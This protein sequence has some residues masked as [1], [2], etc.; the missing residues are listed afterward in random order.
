MLLVAVPWVAADEPSKLRLPPAAQIVADASEVVDARQ[1]VV[2]ARSAAGA[3]MG[4]P[5]QGC[6][7]ALDIGV[8]DAAIGEVADADGGPPGAVVL[9]KDFTGGQ[10]A[11]TAHARAVAGLITAPGRLLGA[12]LFNAAVVGR[13]PNQAAAASA[14]AMVSALDW[15]TASKVRLVNVS[16]AGPC[17]KLLDLAVQSATA[18]GMVI[19]AA[20]GNNGPDSSPRYPA[21]FDDV[22]AVTAVDA[23]GQ[24]YAQAVQGLHVDYAAPGV[25]V[26]VEDRG[27]L[28][29]ASGTSVATPLVTARLA[30]DGRM[31]QAH[32]LAAVRAL[33]DR[34]LQDL[35]A[36]GRY[37]V[38]G[39]GL[40]LSDGVCGASDGART[41]LRPSARLTR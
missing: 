25:E 31:R 20:A 13:R 3:M 32:S 38:Y 17:N 18:R 35:G 29:Y 14:D 9:A 36:A 21:A 19:V 26:L 39:A 41:G 22:L 5:V 30:A 7:A 2:L 8:I 24:V 6:A 10:P 15:L 37:P 23:A 27:T 12:R 33:L 40:V 16:L 34:S 4:W 1:I 28:R 11:P